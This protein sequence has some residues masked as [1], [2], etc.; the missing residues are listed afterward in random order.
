M[1][2]INLD[3]QWDDYPEEPLLYDGSSLHAIER[4]LTLTLSLGRLRAAVTNVVG[5]TR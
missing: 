4:L 2:L 3:L 5:V 1:P